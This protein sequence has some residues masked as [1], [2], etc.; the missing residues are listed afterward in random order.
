[1][2]TWKLLATIPPLVVWIAVFLYANRIDSRIKAMERE[3]G[4]KS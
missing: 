1:M 2:E 4:G 3:L